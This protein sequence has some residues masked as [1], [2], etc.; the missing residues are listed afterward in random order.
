MALEHQFKV[1]V[2]EGNANYEVWY[3]GFMGAYLRDGSWVYVSK[4]LPAPTTPTETASSPITAEEIKAYHV[5]NKEYVTLINK[6]KGTIYL[7]VKSGPLNHLTGLT[8]LYKMLAKLEE[9]Y[10]TKSYT[11]RDQ[12]FNKISV[13]T[14]GEAIK[15]AANS[16]VEMKYPMPEWMLS[17]SFIYDLGAGFKD[18]VTLILNSRIKNEAGIISEPNIDTMIADLTDREKRTK[19][20][21]E[22]ESQNSK[23]T[24][25]LKSA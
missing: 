10:K 20:S 12:Y 18:Y 9:V 11:A 15:K 3:N 17:T 13:V 6:A 25:A 14:Y 1:L 5:E 2:L 19:G 7:T 4:Q 16:L 23:D 21:K 24:K 8:N 22:K